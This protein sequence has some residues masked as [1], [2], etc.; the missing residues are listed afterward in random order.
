MESKMISIGSYYSIEHMY[1][2]FDSFT[3]INAHI[4]LRKLY[5]GT[6]EEC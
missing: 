4:N 5:I 2:L 1:S 3:N 6:V